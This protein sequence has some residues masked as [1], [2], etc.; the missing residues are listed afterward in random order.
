MDARKA[1][2]GKKMEGKEA[3]VRSRSR[4]AFSEALSSQQ[5]FLFSR[6]WRKNRVWITLGG[7]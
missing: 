2:K 1:R 5:I 7:S 4:A 3:G 6:Q